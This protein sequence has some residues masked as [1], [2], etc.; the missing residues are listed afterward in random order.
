MAALSEARRLV[1][2]V[3]ANNGTFALWQQAVAAGDAALA[4]Q[5]ETELSDD[6][7]FH[8]YRQLGAALAEVQ[9]MVTK[10]ID[11][12]VGLADRISLL[13]VVEAVRQRAG[14]EPC[15][16]CADGTGDAAA[17]CGDGAD[18]PQ[19]VAELDAAAM[20]AEIS[21][22]ARLNRVLEMTAMAHT[23]AVVPVWPAQRDEA[24]VAIVH[25]DAPPAPLA[26]GEAKRPRLV[27]LFR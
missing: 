15:A 17:C 11:A 25:M 20:T 1:A 19:L 7:V 2:M 22:G 16:E 13:R 27:W 18:A 3:L 8:A 10:V 5:Y 24:Q 26:A 14:V 21:L 9:P 12:G 4:A 23:E 6:K